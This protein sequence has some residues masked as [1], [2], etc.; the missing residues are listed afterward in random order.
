MALQASQQLARAHHNRTLR[1]TTPRAPHTPVLMQI[2]LC[3]G[4]VVSMFAN[5]ELMGQRDDETES[6]APQ[7][8]S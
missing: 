4:P 8:Y 3:R 2:R 5:E 6:K 7:I 1:I